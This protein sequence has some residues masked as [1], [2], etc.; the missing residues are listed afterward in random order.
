MNVV[1]LRT[2]MELR[3]EPWIPLE[4][5]P[6]PRKCLVVSRMFGTKL[7]ECDAVQQA[8]TLRKPGKSTGPGP[9]SSPN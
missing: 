7:T 9:V 1:G 3:G 5:A 2:A 8:L 6:P 4:L